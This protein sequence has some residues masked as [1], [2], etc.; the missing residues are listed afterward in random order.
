MDNP[1]P[2]VSVTEMTDE[3]VWRAIRDLDP[4]QRRNARDL[5]CVIAIV[6]A[7]VVWHWLIFAASK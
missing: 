2:D 6:L 1:Q 7:C 5:A 4:D 3:E